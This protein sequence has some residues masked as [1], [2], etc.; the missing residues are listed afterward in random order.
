MRAAPEMLPKKEGFGVAENEKTVADVDLQRRDMSLPVPAARI[1]A[2]LLLW[3]IRAVILVSSSRKTGLWVLNVLRN[4]SFK[5]D[6]G[7]W[8]CRKRPRNQE[9]EA[10][11]DQSHISELF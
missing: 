8:T 7:I 3:R 5:E 11:C 10:R 9:Q 4:V 2:K 1:G 6:F